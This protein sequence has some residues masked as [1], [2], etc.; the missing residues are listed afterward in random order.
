M[1][2]RSFLAHRFGLPVA[3]V[4]VRAE[5]R[6]GSKVQLTVDAVR[7]LRDVLI[8]RRAAAKGV[9]DPAHPEP[10]KNGSSQGQN[11]GSHG[12]GGSPYLRT[13]TA[14]PGEAVGKPASI[15]ADDPR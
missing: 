11:S 2:F 8:V 9:Y 1:L 15:P 6:D 12:R 14:T 4:S 13:A 3:E 10:G 5:E 7:M